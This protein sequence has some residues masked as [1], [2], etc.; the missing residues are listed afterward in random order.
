MI[1]MIGRK[2]EEKCTDNKFVALKRNKRTADQPSKQMLIKFA[3]SA[4]EPLGQQTDLN[5]DVIMVLRLTAAI[6]LLLPLLLFY[7]FL[8][9]IQN[10]LILSDY[11][12]LGDVNRRTNPVRRTYPLHFN[13]SALVGL[14]S[15]KLLKLQQFSMSQLQHY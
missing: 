4:V 15:V 6:L 13:I 5:Q 12:F 9:I 8:K 7:N 2:S 10:W 11:L 3:I 1:T 14:S